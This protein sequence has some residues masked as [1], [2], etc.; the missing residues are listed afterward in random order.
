MT[1]QH[2]GASV[3]KGGLLQCYQLQAWLYGAPNRDGDRTLRREAWQASREP[4]AV[5]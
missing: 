2:A 1:N 4:V 3:L 5:A